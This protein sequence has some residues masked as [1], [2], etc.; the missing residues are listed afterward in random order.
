MTS[1]AF[2]N[3]SLINLSS[4]SDRTAMVADVAVVGGDVGR[5]DNVGKTVL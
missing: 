4:I 5:F 2:L 1:M 3:W